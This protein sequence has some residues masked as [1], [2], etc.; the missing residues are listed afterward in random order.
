VEKHTPAPIAH[1]MPMALLDLNRGNDI[2]I[3]PS[4]KRTAI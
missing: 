2:S 4:I 1:M 3:W